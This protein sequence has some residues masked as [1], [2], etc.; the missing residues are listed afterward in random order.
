MNHTQTHQQRRLQESPCLW[1]R[2]IIKATN[3]EKSSK[4]KLL[5][6][7]TELDKLPIFGSIYA[8]ST[9]EMPENIQNK[10]SKRP[11]RAVRE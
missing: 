11:H 7:G 2:T 4:N 9:I 6:Y 8:L 3:S 5:L 10:H 1:R